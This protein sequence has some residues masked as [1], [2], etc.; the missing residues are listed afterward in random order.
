MTVQPLEAEFS[1]SA[2]SKP[3]RRKRP[4]PF[5]IRF[6][7]EER[8]QLDR[9]RGVLSLSAYIRLKLFTEPK[10]QP[11]KRKALVRKHSAPSAELTVLSQML[12]GLGQSRLASNIN[13]I[14]K[15]ANMGALPVNPG[16]E[17]ELADACAAIQ[18]MKSHLVTAL[19]I[20]DK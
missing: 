4:P 13:Q 10:N 11:S 15:A 12:G 9:E 2:G 18:D 3:K 7:D 19:G 6:S 14:A 8:A 20:K 17:Q 1:L 16:L 5:S